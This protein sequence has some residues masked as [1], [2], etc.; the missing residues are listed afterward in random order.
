MSTNVVRFFGRAFR[1][2][3]SEAGLRFEIVWC[4]NCERDRRLNQDI[5]EAEGCEILANAYV[6]NGAPQWVRGEHGTMCTAFVPE[7]ERA[8]H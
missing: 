2:T 6:H 4:E 3:H 8:P 5:H 7:G 1:P